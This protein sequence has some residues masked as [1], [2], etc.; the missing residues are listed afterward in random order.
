MANLWTNLK[1]MD[2][3]KKHKKF[4]FILWFPE[5]DLSNSLSLAWTTVSRGNVWPFYNLNIENVVFDEY[6]FRISILNETIDW[7]SL[8]YIDAYMWLGCVSIYNLN[9]IENGNCTSY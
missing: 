3:I 2:R 5:Y 4:N 1:R 8:S 9:A 6:Q 7:I